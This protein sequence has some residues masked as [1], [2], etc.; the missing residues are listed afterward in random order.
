[1]EEL[2]I[3]RNVN[4]KE[5]FNSA[6]DLFIDSALTWFRS[7]RSQVNNWDELVS[8]LRR[9]FLPVDFDEKLWLEIKARTQGKKETVNIFVGVMETLF[10]R[11]SR[12]PSEAERLRIIKQN[13]LPQFQTHLALANITSIFQL[14][15]ICRKLED[16]IQVQNSYV[17]PP[18][19]SGLIE[20]NLAYIEETGGSSRN[21]IRKAETRVNTITRDRGPLVCFNCKL[22]NHVF[23][24]CKAK[25]NKF[26]FKCGEPDVTVQ[27]CKKC[28][29][30]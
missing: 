20:K 5:L 28:S 29:K 25:R 9:E 4:K 30:N 23:K 15:E 18:K 21:S 6:I 7:I 16:A 17:P 10:K 22:P 8:L 19:S 14:K 12:P 2:A 24:Q 26:C 3:A 27:T 11:L 13:L 1:V